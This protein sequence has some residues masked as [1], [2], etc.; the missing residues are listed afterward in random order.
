MSHSSSVGTG[1][2]RT[3]TRTTPGQTTIGPAAP[4]AQTLRLRKI[5]LQW[6]LWCL[7][8][9]MIQASPRPQAL[10]RRLQCKFAPQTRLV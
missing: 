9:Q 10:Q 4:W 3:A 2:L 7:S 5:C 8:F 1:T 6:S